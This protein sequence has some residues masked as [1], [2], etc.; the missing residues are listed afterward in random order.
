MRLTLG[1]LKTLGVWKDASW[2]CLGLVVL[3]AL[4]QVNVEGICRRRPHLAVVCNLEVVCNALTAR[5]FGDPLN[6]AIMCECEC[7]CGCGCG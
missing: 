3:K 7:G 6:P 1:S 5:R 2:T 4:V